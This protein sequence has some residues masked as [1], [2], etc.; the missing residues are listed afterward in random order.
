MPDAVNQIWK[1]TAECL[2]LVRIFHL[3]LDVYTQAGEECLKSIAKMKWG[4]ILL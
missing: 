4:S 2:N 3:W 1:Q